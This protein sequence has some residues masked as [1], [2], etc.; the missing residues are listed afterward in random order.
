MLIRL[1]I[2]R[3][4]NDV[5]ALRRRARMRSRFTAR[6]I[7]RTRQ[8]YIRRRLLPAVEMLSVD[9]VARV[10][11]G[12][13]RISFHLAAARVDVLVLWLSGFALCHH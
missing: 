8:H 13:R 9:N 10:G 4:L 2:T 5:Q 7:G 1:H 11:R 12:T 6:A 3:H